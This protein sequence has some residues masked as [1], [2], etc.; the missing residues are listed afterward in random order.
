MQEAARGSGNVG[1]VIPDMD[2]V[3]LREC[4]GEPERHADTKLEESLD[5]CSMCER[6][7]S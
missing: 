5:G 6:S 1:R 7:S 3:W 2:D 4:L